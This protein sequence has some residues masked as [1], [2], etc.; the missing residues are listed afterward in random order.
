MKGK[1]IMRMDILLKLREMGREV[2]SKRRHEEIDF[3]Y[4]TAPCGLPCFE[5]YL[6]KKRRN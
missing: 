4:M 5:S 2:K 6:Y 3:E 1:L